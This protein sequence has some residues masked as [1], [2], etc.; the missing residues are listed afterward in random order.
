MEKYQINTIEELTPELVLALIDRFKLKEVKRLETLQDYYKAHSDIKKRQMA[1]SSKPNNKLAT[2]Y[3][4]YISDTIQGYFQG[5]PVAYTSLDED[6]VAEVQK[7]FNQNREHLLN[8]KV[9]KSMSITGVGYELMYMDEEKN[10]RFSYLDPKQVFM[11]FDTSI[12]ERVLAAVRFYSNHNYITNEDVL[13]VEV[14]TD[15]AIHYYQMGK[16]GLEQE[17]DVETGTYKQEEHFFKEVP[18]IQYKNNDEYMGDFEKVKD[19]I[20][21][22][23]LGV[24]D[25]ANNLE[26]FADSYLLLS[27]EGMDALEPEDIAEMKEKRVMVL[28]ANG[29]AEWLVKG[30]QN[31]EVEAYKDRLKEDIHNMSQVPNLN[32]DAFG[33]ATSGESLKYKLFGLEN[34]VSIKERNFKIGLEQRLKLITNILAVKGKTYDPTNITIAFTRNLPVNNTTLIDMIVKLAG[35]VS[36]KTLLA[37]IPFIEDVDKELKLI[38]DQSPTDNY[39]NVFEED[40]PPIA[41]EETV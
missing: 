8:T 38:Q 17:I 34:L 36:D 19:L 28:G 32:D 24:S 1:D 16:D 31:V 29:K 13:K 22:Y 15:D 11:I 10:I 40:Q 12:E 39:S 9:G 6:F 5:K 27:G 21:A 33:T 41:T 2:P 23:D 20:D 18:V 7:I 35:I 26:Y 14:F 3:A 4:S 25:T 30:T 37:Q